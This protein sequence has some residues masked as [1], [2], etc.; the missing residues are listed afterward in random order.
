LQELECRHAPSGL[1]FIDPD[2]APGNGFGTTVVPLSTGNVVITSPFDNAGGTGAGAVYLFNGNTRALISTLTGSHAND[3]IG[4]NGVV[5]LTNGN[6][7]VSSQSWDN[8]A[9]VD[10]GA[11]TWGSGTSGVSG[12][13]SAANSLVGSH[14]KDYLGSSMTVLP[15]GNYVVSSAHWDNGASVDAGA[16]TWGNGATG[17]LGV[18]SAANSLVGD[19]GY[20]RVGSDGVVVLSNGNYVVYSSG[21]DNGA[22]VGAGAVTWG[23]GTSGV[24]GVVSAANSLVGSHADDQVG[25]G[26]VALTNGNYVV[27]SP[28]WYSDTTVEPGAVTWGN[29]ATGIAGVVSTANSLVGSQDGDAVGVGGVVALTNGNYVVSSPS[30]NNGAI[31]GAGAVTWCSGTTGLTGVV[32]T[33]NSLVGSQNDDQVGVVSNANGTKGVVALTNGNYI[34]ASPNWDNGAVVDA[35]AVTWGNGTSGV[36]GVVSTANSLVGSQ[37]GDQV[38]SNYSRVGVAALTNGNYV[39]SSPFWDNGAVVDAG[40]VTWGNGSTGV[41]GVVSAANSLIGSQNGDFVGSSQFGVFRVTALTNGNYVVVS[42]YWDNGAVVD[43]GA[44]TWGNGTSGVTGVV[45]ATNSL[46]G[47]QNGD[48]VGYSDNGIGVVALAN[49]NYV[50]DSPY[51]D[52]GAVVDAGAVT[53]GNGTCGVTGV[54][55]A[56][57]SL[58]GSQTKDSFGRDG[59]VALTNGNYVVDSSGWDN[60]AIAGAGA[61]TWGN[62]ATGITG[63]LSA[64]NSLIGSQSGDAVGFGL[65]GSGGVFTLT[66]GNYVVSSPSW[67]NG[68]VVYAGAATWGN[69]N[70]GVSGAVTA[71]NSLIGG[72]SSAGSSDPYMRIVSDS[73]NGTFYGWWRYDGGGHVRIGSQDYG[74]ANAP[75]VTSA[76]LGDGTDQRSMVKQVVVNFSTPVTFTGASAFKVTRAGPGGTMGDVTLTTNPASGT[77]GSVTIAFSGS[78]SENGSLV[79]GRYVFSIDATRVSAGGIP[80]DGDGNGLPGGNYT[81]VGTP[82]NK[83]FRLFGDVNGDGTVDASDFITFRQYFGGVLFA[84]D[85]DGDGSVSANDFVQFRLRFGGSI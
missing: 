4:S 75:T 69:G 26:I 71:I 52:N 10:A 40:A 62:G 29:G 6:Y 8:G 68:A 42:P 2:P 35:G 58:V 12:V 55:S 17:V 3:Q 21:W 36:T 39:V 45:S 24:S 61:V 84:F 60:G 70:T 16:V 38:G 44:V 64:A 54:V 47:S 1:E 65:F 18:V 57:N 63:I 20:D 9:V 78:L 76:V 77:A 81:I 51:W 46:V 15:N 74:F 27:S 14:S 48:K 28:F 37:N 43:A 31:L 30:W 34:V 82:A 25:Y 19:Q 66:N 67:N 7:L 56:T 11:V 53:W 80:L 72:P 50:V 73:V 85:F 22:T 33:A 5:A 23:S 41:T 13:V 83:W 79:D 32:S 49:G 59:V